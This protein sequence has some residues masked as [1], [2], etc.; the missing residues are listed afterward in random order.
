M[1]YTTKAKI[2]SLLSTTTD[3]TLAALAISWVT[4]WINKYTG[5]T[6]EAASD[7]RYYDLDGGEEIIIDSFVGTPSEVSILNLNGGVEKTLV[8][9]DG[10][11]YITIPFNLTEKSTIRLNSN[12]GYGTFPC[13][14]RGLKVTASFGYSSAVPAAI[15][16]VATQLAASVTSD[17]IG[18]KVTS[19]SL[20]DYSVSYE[21][22]DAKA[23]QF[24][25]TGTLDMYRDIEI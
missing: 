12:G 8:Y 2:D 9:G 20:G 21:N 1:A 17:L 24:G 10:N 22:I 16:M 14:G 7:T 23:Q 11:D 15:E 5:K 19:Q 18:K 13:R 6:F 3:A 4:D 25:S